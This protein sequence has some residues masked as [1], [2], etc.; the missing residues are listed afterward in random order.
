MHPC[1]GFRTA[2]NA[3]TPL[4]FMSKARNYLEIAR[5]F[6]GLFTT[7]PSPPTHDPPRI[8]PH[9]SPLVLLGT[10]PSHFAETRG[11][12]SSQITHVVFGIRPQV[13]FGSPA[14]SLDAL[15]VGGSGGQICAAD[16]VVRSVICS[17]RERPVFGTRRNEWLRRT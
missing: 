14:P 9:K 17:S 10:N 16:D 2:T 3:G 4:T 1:L 7:T 5:H 11:R 8:D 15:A 6:K 12:Q 13:L